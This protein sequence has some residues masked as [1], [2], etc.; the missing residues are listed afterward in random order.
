MTAAG[1]C[2]RRITILTGHYG[3][4]KTEFAVNLAL[5]LA[6]EGAQVMLADLDNVNPYFRSRER[7]ALLEEAGVRLIAAP[8][9]CVDAD[10]PAVP[11]ELL[12]VLEDRSVRGVLDIGGDPAG[13]RAL[14]RFQPKLLQED[15][16]LLYVLNANRPEVRTAET[17]AACLRAIE[18]TTGLTCSALVNNTHLC[19]ETTAA[20]IRKGAALAAAVSRETGLPVLCHTAEKRLAPGLTGLDAPVFPITVHMKKPWE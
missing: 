7:K 18:Q 11:A 14:A 13:A 6:A 5:S 15:C 20:D 3:T 2:T 4:G 16:Q 9:A 12:T 19:G 1:I 17:A 8:Q 10:V